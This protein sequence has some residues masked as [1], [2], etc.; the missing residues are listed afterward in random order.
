MKRKDR[1]TAELLFLFVLFLILY[2]FSTDISNFFASMETKFEFKAIKS[3]FWFLSLFFKWLENL[4][5]IS[6]LYAIISGIIYLNWRRK[7]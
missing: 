2:A 7:Y 5:F 3:L 1:L 4:I 6:T